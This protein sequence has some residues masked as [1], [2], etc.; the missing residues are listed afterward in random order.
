LRLFEGLRVSINDSI[1]DGIHDIAL[2]IE[3]A[4]PGQHFVQDSRKCKLVGPVIDLTHAP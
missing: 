2:S 4:F 3:G 1:Q